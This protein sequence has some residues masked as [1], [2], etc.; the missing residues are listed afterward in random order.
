MSPDESYAESWTDTSNGLT[1]ELE[2]GEPNEATLTA[3][4]GKT[5]DV[6]IPSK[7][8]ADGVDYNVLR[9]NQSVFAGKDVK[10]VEIGS[11][12]DIDAK[13]FLDCIHLENVT[14]S[15]GID[16]ISIGVFNGC[17]ELKTAD[18]P[19]SIIKIG[20]DAFKGTKIDKINLSN[21]A[22]IG[23]NAFRG[24]TNLTSLDMPSIESLGYRC[25]MDCENIES[26]VF[27]EK[28]TT[29]NQFAFDNTKI[30]TFDLPATFRDTYQKGFSL[31]WWPTCLE[32]IKINDSNPNFCDDD[33]VVYN[34]EK[35]L[36][37]LLPPSKTGE[38][39]ALANNYG[40]SLSQI[41][42]D[43]LVFSDNVT[44]VS[45]MCY[46]NL[47]FI[48]S[49]V[50]EVIFPSSVTRISSSFDGCNQ[51]ERVD[52]GGITAISSCFRECSSLT[53]VKMDCVETISSS[54]QE[55]PKLN[56]KLPESIKTFDV[57]TYKNGSRVC[58]F[59]VDS[60]TFPSESVAGN[61]STTLL[62]YESNKMDFPSIGSYNLKDISGQT[63][64]VIDYTKNCS[65]DTVRYAFHTG[66]NV[67]MIMPYS[68]VDP[69][70]ITY[71]DEDG[72]TILYTDISTNGGEPSYEIPDREGY[73]GVWE[74]NEKANTYVLH[75]YPIYK[76]SF[77]DESGNLVGETEF[78]ENDT[79]LDEPE[80]PAKDGY[81]G[82]WTYDIMA[83][84]M[85][86]KPTYAA[87]VYEATFVDEAGNTVG[88]TGFTVRDKILDEP[89][90]PVKEGYD[91]S[92]IYEVKAGN[93]VVKPN[94]V[95]FEEED[96][97]GESN[98]L[99]YAAVAVVVVIIVAIA[100]AYIKRN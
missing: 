56:L 24:C 96:S 72:K 32:A 80:V 3:W 10:T 71:L 68:T 60:I 55:C 67:L 38:Y 17:T 62:R 89:E 49:T 1:Y 11:N 4:D 94:Y 18:I 28:L 26:C 75:Y 85:V 31:R 9:I 87:I 57:S 93:M 37:L 53:E 14:I 66:W 84:N 16:A 40:T 86:I 83:E 54:F 7:I 69:A 45:R 20:Q 92:W 33:G 90:V 74:T 46:T 21:V 22:I 23:D 78:T 58:I 12:I 65:Y 13:A 47:G 15:E 29:I 39:T 44:S 34:K 64:D 43:K 79:T 82:S 19:N 52:L 6:K 59:Y 27:G 36:L 42:L 5:K 63:I 76:A 25:F 95:A 50:K 41:S 97:D 70:K 99:I 35:T 98:T 81:Y 30:K 51:L 73:V 61:L 88:K 2:K 8:T 100:I 48:P 77:V 91:G